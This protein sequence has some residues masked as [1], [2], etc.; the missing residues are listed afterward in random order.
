MEENTLPAVLQ[1][2]RAHRSV[3]AFSAAPVADD[4]VRSVVETAQWASSS[5]FRQV[6]S[7]IAVRDPARKQH[8]RSLCGE[9]P[10]VEKAPVFLAFCADLSR[11]DDV[12]QAQGLQVNLEYTETFLMAALDA[13][14]VMQNAALAAEACGL[15]I[16]MI[17]GLRNHPREVA[18]LLELPRGVVGIC[19]MCLGWPV[20]Q[21]AP[22]PRLPLDEVLH[23]ETYDRSGRA[24]RL[25]EYDR[26][27]VA[28]GLYP[29][30]NGAPRTWSAV[31]AAAASRPPAERGRQDLREIL[32]ERG[33]EM[34]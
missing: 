23:W 11:L 1:Q 3:R 14:L 30:P 4:L 26:T 20:R 5:S 21:P 27:I 24:E 28:A 13:A 25:A 9:Q 33:F 10:W 2:I 29:D 6:Y 34:K 22:R 12:C 7:V 31:M 15:G 17:G 8:L 19:G 32:I 16:V 18:D